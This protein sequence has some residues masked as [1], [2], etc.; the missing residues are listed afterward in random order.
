MITKYA[1][2]SCKTTINEHQTSELGPNWR[3]K[4]LTA[5]YLFSFKTYTNTYRG[6]LYVVTFYNARIAREYIQLFMSDVICYMSKRL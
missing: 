3:I 1:F 5:W 2:E 6:A 4:F